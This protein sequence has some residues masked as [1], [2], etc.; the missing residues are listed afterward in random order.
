[1]RCSRSTINVPEDVDWNSYIYDMS[2][3]AFPAIYISPTFLIMEAV[4]LIAVLV[5][6]L[7]DG[8]VDIYFDDN[9][10]KILPAL[11]YW[12]VGIISFTV[13]ILIYWGMQQ[14]LSSKTFIRVHIVLTLVTWIV[15][16][17]LIMQSDEIFPP[18]NI[19]GLSEATVLRFMYYY[20]NAML[21]YSS[22]FF[23]A[24]TA[25]VVFVFHLVSAQFTKKHPTL[26]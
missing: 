2:K 11:F 4:I 19:Q 25:Q 6:L 17:I 22:L 24:V 3:N 12:W 26:S 10:S 8:P 5:L 14:W 9:Y 23:V 15:A 21:I 13:T 16:A 18:S 1:M 7:R 20:R